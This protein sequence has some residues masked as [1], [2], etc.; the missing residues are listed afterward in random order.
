MGAANI[1]TANGDVNLTADDMTINGNLVLGSGNLVLT[2]TDAGQVI[3]LG[4]VSTGAR[5][6]LEDA[7]LDRISTSGNVTIGTSSQT[8][9]I[10][11]S[12]GISQAGSGYTK[13]FLTTAARSAMHTQLQRTLPSM[14]CSCRP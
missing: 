12:N 14:I 11:V 4:N 5:L 3:D 8:A 6:G 9:G 1:A 7:E 10:T 13:L 2:T